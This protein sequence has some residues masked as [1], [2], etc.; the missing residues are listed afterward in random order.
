MLYRKVGMA[1][2]GR[3]PG[4]EPIKDLFSPEELT[5]YEDERELL[6]GLRVA[7]LCNLTLATQYGVKTIQ[8]RTISWRAIAR[9]GDM[10]RTLSVRRVRPIPSVVVHLR[11]YASS[12]WQGPLL[13]MLMWRA[14]PPGAARRLQTI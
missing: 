6:A 14:G 1:G 5:I 7:S 9:D 11:R 2:S 10:S 3:R 12:S 8:V 13:S 4:P